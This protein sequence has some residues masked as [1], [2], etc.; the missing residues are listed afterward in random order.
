MA[1]SGH[2]P[3]QRTCPLSGVKQTWPFAAHMSAFDPK[4]TLSKLPV[5]D[6]YSASRGSHAAMMA[7]MRERLGARIMRERSARKK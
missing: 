6:Q 2:E 4:R 1:Q 7:D 3:V 5:A